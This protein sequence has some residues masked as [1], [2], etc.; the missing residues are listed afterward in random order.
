MPKFEDYFEYANKKDYCLYDFWLYA[1][2]KGMINFNNNKETMIRKISFVYYNKYPKHKENIFG[3][4][5]NEGYNWEL[6][7]GE[8]SNGPF[9]DTVQGKAHKKFDRIKLGKF[10]KDSWDNAYRYYVAKHENLN[11]EFQ[12]LSIFLLQAFF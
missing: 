8:I 3:T 4:Y 2:L 12:K 1:G 9:V 6:L 5:S 11:S 7:Y 10:A